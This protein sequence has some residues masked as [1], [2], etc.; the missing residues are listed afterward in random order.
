MY[1]YPH[2]GRRRDHRSI[3]VPGLYTALGWYTTKPRSNQFSSTLLE[4]LA[5]HVIN[6]LLASPASFCISDLCLCILLWVICLQKVR[7]LYHW[8]RKKKKPEV[9][10]SGVYELQQDF[11]VSLAQH[12]QYILP[13]SHSEISLSWR[14]KSKGFPIHSNFQIEDFTGLMQTQT[15]LLHK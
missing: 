13:S 7:K 15:M 5:P 3:Q 9:R 10:W 12:F 2:V 6:V 4:H 11:C 14:Q 8:K 1:S